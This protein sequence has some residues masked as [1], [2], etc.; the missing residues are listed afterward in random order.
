LDVFRVLTSKLLNVPLD[1]LRLFTDRLLNAPSD[2]SRLFTE[3]LLN[4]PFNVYDNKDDILFTNMLL[5][6]AFEQASLLIFTLLKDALYVLSSFMYAFDVNEFVVY[7]N[8]V[9]IFDE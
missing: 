5:K 4:D 8:T 2:A 3:R 7:D 9:L 6:D 1:V